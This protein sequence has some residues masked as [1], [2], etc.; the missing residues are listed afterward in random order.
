VS[1]RRRGGKRGS[2]HS[3]GAR[4]GQNRMSLRRHRAQQAPR[5]ALA[6]SEHG[7]V[8][9]NKKYGLLQARAR[10]ARHGRGCWALPSQ[11]SSW[12]T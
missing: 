5:R 8:N 4:V 11:I 6:G 7:N 10:V 12:V 3:N 1:E 9:K 2:G